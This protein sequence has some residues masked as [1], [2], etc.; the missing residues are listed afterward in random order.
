MGL[1]CFM[2]IL[3][4]LLGLLSIAAFFI[5]ALGLIKPSWMG[6]EKRTSVLKM[7]GLAF[8][9]FV[10]ALLISPGKTE[11]SQNVLPASTTDSVKAEEQ[12]STQGAANEE[13]EKL[14][15]EAKKAKEEAA[16]AKAEI[17]Q[18]KADTEAANAEKAKADEEAVKAKTDK[19][20]EE[21]K[22]VE[23]Y[24]TTA[25]KLYQDYEANEVA[26]DEKIGGRPV[27]IS[28]KVESID[29]GLFDT[30]VIQMSTGQMFMNAGLSMED[31]EKAQAMKTSKG[32]KVT[33]VCQSMS[34]LIGMPQGN[35]C[36]FK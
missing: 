29:K 27:E 31:S 30:I 6:K 3:S 17:A 35:G 34:R 22:P 14:K 12:P 13:A 8:L 2:E 1:E 28:G 9:V 5:L 20:A 7:M 11:Q 4:P 26:T 15:A 23:A 16:Q 18:A 19:Q 32:N 21:N 25:A 33:I 36:V 24:K 10:V